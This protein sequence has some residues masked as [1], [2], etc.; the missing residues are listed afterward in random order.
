MPHSEA[1]TIGG[2]EMPVGSGSW[3]LSLE[4]EGWGDAGRP[5]GRP[6]R[7]NLN[8]DSGSECVVDSESQEES[9]CESARGKAPGPSAW[10]G[11]ERHASAT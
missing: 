8:G 5:G 11:P 6:G 10:A 4:E 1:A 7:A 9:P 3:R 2:E